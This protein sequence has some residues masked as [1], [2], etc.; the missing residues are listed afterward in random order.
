MEKFHIEFV[1]GKIS[2]ISLWNMIST[3]DGLNGWFAD[4]VT[5]TD[6]IKY[7]FT[8]NK[9]DSIALMISQKPSSF[10]RFQWEEREDPATYFEFRIHIMELSKDITLEITDFA[11]HE[12]KA[13]A[14]FLWESQ[15][16]ILKRK[17]GA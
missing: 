11:D 14:I 17:L 3:A 10:I 12:D 16:E 6:D 9:S 8:W 15:M 13:D 2:V 4:K 1:L 5:I 7:T